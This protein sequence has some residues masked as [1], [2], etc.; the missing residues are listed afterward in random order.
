M[1]VPKQDKC[2][3]DIK[4]TDEWLMVNLEKWIRTGFKN[5]ILHLD[6]SNVLSWFRIRIEKKIVETKPW[7]RRNVT[8]VKSMMDEVWQVIYES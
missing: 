3:Q 7:H 2:W 4:P 6:I 8:R 1:T 5:N